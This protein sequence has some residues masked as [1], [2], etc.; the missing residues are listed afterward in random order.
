[1]FLNLAHRGASAYAPENTLAAFYKGVEQGANG[2]ETDLKMTRD[3][4]AILFHDAVLDR[5]TNGTGEPGAY[6]WD[7]LRQLDAGAWFSFRYQGE[8]LVSFEQFLYAFGSKDLAF[9]CELKD[10]QIEDSVLALIDR[11]RAAKKVVI[12]SFHYEDLVEVRRRNRNIKLGYL[13]EQINDETLRKV[14]DIGARQ[15]CPRVETLQPEEVKLA[16]ERGLKVRGWGASTES[17]M[18]Y[19]LYCGV[20]GMT[21]NFPDKLA[22]ARQKIRDISLL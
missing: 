13:V 22:D 9:A 16:K 17:L 6:T 1:M 3:G 19:A 18:N 8:K 21:V 14:L 15:I 11:Y 4:V 7:E 10:R 2:I 20:D 5:T 12:T